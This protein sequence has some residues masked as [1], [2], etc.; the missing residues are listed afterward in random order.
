METDRSADID[1]AFYHFRVIGGLADKFSLPSI[2]AGA[3]GLDSLDGVV[4]FANTQILPVVM[5]LPMGWAWS[6]P[7]CYDACHVGLRLHTRP[8]HP[9]PKHIPNHRT[10][11]RLRGG[12][13]RRERSRRWDFS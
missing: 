7:K 5:V 3:L 10:F 2:P 1:N 4:L 12:R 9:G 6:L 8:H 13:L 11:D